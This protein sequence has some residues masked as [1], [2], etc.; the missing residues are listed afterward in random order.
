PSIW[1]SCSRSSSLALR[2][3]APTADAAAAAGAAPEARARKSSGA[4]HAAPAFARWILPIF[5]IS[6]FTA[7]LYEVAWT[8]I[9]AVPFGG[10]VYAFSAI[11]A[12]YLVGIAL[13][14]A[15]AARLLR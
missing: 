8:R 9:L 6:G 13:G 2:R 14:A 11:L 3:L 4:P 15:G 12:I 1:R 10:M 5:A 7:I